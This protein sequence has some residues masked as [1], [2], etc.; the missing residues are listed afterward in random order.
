MYFS[1]FGPNA[2]EG[3]EAILRRLG[4]AY[5]FND[6]ASRNPSTILLPK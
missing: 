2:W 6:G 1:F 3:V 5:A 4:G